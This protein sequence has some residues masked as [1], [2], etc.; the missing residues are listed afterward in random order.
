MGENDPIAEALKLK[1]I[2]NLNFSQANVN[3]SWIICQNFFEILMV[4]INLE[5]MEDSHEWLD[6]E[7]LWMKNKESKN[8]NRNCRELKN[9]SFVFCYYFL[10]NFMWWLWVF[11]F[12]VNFL[13]NSHG[14]L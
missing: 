9:A 4:K 7:E 1:L 14:D 2:L 6:E 12:S 10:G 11:G 13:L 5:K 8:D 3:R